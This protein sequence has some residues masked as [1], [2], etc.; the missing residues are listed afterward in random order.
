MADSWVIVQGGQSQSVELQPGGLG[1]RD[2]ME[3]KFQVTDGPAKGTYGQVQI[4]LAVYSP[5]YVRDVIED[6]V[7]QLNAV[8]GL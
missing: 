4:P 6:R 1:F 2:V 7:A 8:A 5:D 3:V